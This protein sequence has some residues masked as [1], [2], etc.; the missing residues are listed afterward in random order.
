MNEP[1]DIRSDDPNQS[2]LRRRNFGA[3]WAHAVEGREYTKDTLAQLTWQN[4]GWRLGSILE[5]TSANPTSADLIDEM[6]DWCVRQQAE[7]G[8]PER[9]ADSSSGT[10]EAH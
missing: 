7:T 6:Y 10:D 9:M 1:T 4:L 5:V 2:Q 8:S 3:G